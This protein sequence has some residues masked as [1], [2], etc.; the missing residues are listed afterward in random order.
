MPIHWCQQLRT[1]TSQGYA[2]GGITKLNGCQ[3]GRFA[4]KFIYYFN[5][6]T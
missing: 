5:A 4:V 3:A 2:D 6:V 1:P